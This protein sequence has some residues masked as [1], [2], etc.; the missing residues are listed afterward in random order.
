[1]K[2]ENKQGFTIL[3]IMITIVILS[4]IVAF[5]IPSFTKSIRRSQLRAARLNLIS[6]HASQR[7]YKAKKANYYDFNGSETLA[8]T[9]TI[10]DLNNNDDVHTYIFT[11]DLTSFTIIARPA[12]SAYDLTITEAAVTSGNPAC[13]GTCP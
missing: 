10:F 6:I 4:V 13:T 5:T 2:K 8:S 11:G 3:E 7:I 12:D 1:M 9:N